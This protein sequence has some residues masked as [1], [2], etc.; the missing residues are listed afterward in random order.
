MAY[1][2]ASL[3]DLCVELEL[4][5]ARAQAEDA[6]LVDYYTAALAEQDVVAVHLDFLHSRPQLLFSSS[7]TSRLLRSKR[8][9]EAMTFQDS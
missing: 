5:E 1:L 7:A 4:Q 6:F 2:R 9:Y 3:F 8:V